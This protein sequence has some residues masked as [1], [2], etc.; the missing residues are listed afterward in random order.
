MN[1]EEADAIKK[2][3]ISLNLANPTFISVA[4]NNN[5][6]YQILMKT[7]GNVNLIRAFLSNKKLILNEDRDNDTCTIYEP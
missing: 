3:L 7:D 5:G 4:K 1:R 6:K 2:E